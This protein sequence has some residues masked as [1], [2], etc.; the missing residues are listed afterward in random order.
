[1]ADKLYCAYIMSNERRTVLYAGITSD[2]PRRSHEHKDHVVGGFT[3]KYNVDRL[4]W[5]ECGDDVVGA[6][7]R[8]KQIKAG[9]RRKK[10]ELIERMNPDWRDLSEDL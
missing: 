6:I 5:Y 10:I 8:E 7:E 1:M 2:L 4:V 3:K 9:P